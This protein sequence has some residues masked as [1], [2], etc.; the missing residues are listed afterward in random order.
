ME[1][2]GAEIPIVLQDRKGPVFKS[3]PGNKSQPRSTRARHYH[4]R[5]TAAV[6]RAVSRVVTSQA[7]FELDLIETACRDLVVDSEKFHDLDLKLRAE[8]KAEAEGGGWSFLP[9]VRTRK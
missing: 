8:A 4:G 6:S 7:G 3:Q 5:P 9:S 2:V 1:R